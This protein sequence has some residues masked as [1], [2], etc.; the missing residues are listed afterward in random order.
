MNHS[1]A[2]GT[3][4]GQKRPSVLKN[5]RCLLPCSSPKLFFTAHLK[6]GK[7]K[8]VGKPGAPTGHPFQGLP[9]SR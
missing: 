1:E 7:H 9:V 5:K 6:V 3:E 8:E 4:K 2:T